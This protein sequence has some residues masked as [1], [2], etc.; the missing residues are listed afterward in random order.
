MFTTRAA[1]SQSAASVT[2]APDRDSGP[3]SIT[4]RSGSSSGR[5]RTSPARGS[6]A[7]NGGTPSAATTSACFPIRSAAMRRAM[8]APSESAS[9]FSWQMVVMRVAERSASSTASRLTGALL[10]ELVE[11]LQHAVAGL[12]RVVEADH[13]LRHL[14]HRDA[15][16][17]LPAHPWGGIGQ[18]LDGG[19]LLLRRPHDADPYPSRA[20][21][22]GG[23]HAR[24]GGEP[25]SRVLHLA[26]EELHEL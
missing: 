7:R 15:L 16:A 13:Q 24:D 8:A 17:Q 1:A 9:G 19:R 22:A 20:E 10:L 18:G 12:D 21:I 4:A 23:L 3:S 5:R 2:T 26:L 14:S 25:D 11:Q 6:P